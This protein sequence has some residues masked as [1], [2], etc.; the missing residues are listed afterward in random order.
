MTC[1]FRCSLFDLNDTESFHDR[2]RKKLTAGLFGYCTRLILRIGIY[3]KS[4]KFP[5]AHIAPLF[6]SDQGQQL[7]DAT[8]ARSVCVRSSRRELQIQLLMLDSNARPD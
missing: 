6:E 5:D 4:D 7:D 2:V 3:N 1:S 8:L